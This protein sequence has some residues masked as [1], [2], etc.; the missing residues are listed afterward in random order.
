[1]VTLKDVFGVEQSRAWLVCGWVTVLDTGTDSPPLK[2]I[3]SAKIYSSF[4]IEYLH[5]SKWI[6]ILGVYLHLRFQVLFWG[7]NSFSVINRFHKLLSL[8]LY[9]PKR[10]WTSKWYCSSKGWYCLK[11]TRKLVI[12]PFYFLPFFKIIKCA[13][14]TL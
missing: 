11:A 14:E 3:W 8:L 6:Y 5:F 4:S 10:S 13:L 9:S 12:K 1:M 7:R 2:L